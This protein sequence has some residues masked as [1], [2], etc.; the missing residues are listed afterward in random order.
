MKRWTIVVLNLFCF[1]AMFLFAGD[2]KA[3]RRLPGQVNGKSILL[4]NGWSLSPAGRHIPVGDFPLALALHQN[5]RHLL[6]ANNGYGKQSIDVI[7]VELGK[8]VSSEPV[9][10]AWLGLTFNP[11]GTKA[12]AGGGMSNS[13]L[14]FAFNEGKLSPLPPLPVGR[15]LADIFPGGLCISGGRLF[16]A[17]NLSGDVA[18]LDLASGKVAASVKVGDYPYTCAASADGRMVYVSLWGGSQV[19]GIETDSLKV[20]ARIQTED[21]PNAMLFSRDGKRLFVANANNNSVSAIDLAAGK[22]LERISVALYPDSPAGSTTNALA[23]SPDGNTLYVANADNNDLAV[24]DIRK[25]GESK[26]LGFI[27]VGWYPTSVATSRDGRMIYVAN[28]KGN[29]S[30]ANPKGPVTTMPRTSAT[31]Y[32]G[33]LLLGS[34]SLV[35]VPDQAMLAKYTSEV[36]ANIP[37]SEKQRLSVNFKGKSS[38]PL[39]V[40]DKSP[41]EHVIYVIKENRTYDQV[42]GDIKEGNGDPSLT[43]FGEQITPNQHALAREFV[44]LDNFYVDAEVS[45]DGHNWSMGAYA[46]DYVE[47]IWPSQYSGRRRLYDFEGGS[48]VVAPSEGYIWDAC[49]KAGI[50]YRSYGEWVAN[51]ARPGDP[52]RA[53]AS[54]LEGHFDPLYR[55][56]DMQYS[57]IDRAKRFL[58]EVARFEK[59]GGMPRFQVVRMGNDHTQGTKAGTL[60]PS[61]YVAQNDAAL[62]MLVEG[63][64][65]STFWPKTA[66]F[67][68]EDDAQNGP[69]HVDAHRSIAFAISPYIRR[70]TVDSTMYSTSSMLRTMELILGL[71]PMSQYDAAAAPLMASF[72]TKPDLKPFN[73]LPPRVSLTEVN[74]ANAPGAARSSQMDFDEADRAPDLEFN[75]ILWKAIKG[76]DSVMPAPVRSAFVRPIKMDRD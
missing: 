13:V 53:K 9:E 4:P 27:P 48:P 20:K 70:G 65:K 66:I 16:V 10:K 57:D 26:V 67:V 11:D 44:L 25:S 46:T 63:V 60:T 58:S 23:M 75:E 45:A 14:S 36:Y 59:E 69:D 76:G 32:I 61:A 51:G 30:A 6:V 19:V 8:V 68:V 15:P 1:A 42:F 50:T 7:D 21:H 34:V 47:K 40:G 33:G 55:G 41:I 29:Q 71:P 56:W 38:I 64:S 5:G 3:Q 39:K 24:V 2:Q 37:Y 31:Q 72:G 52:S 22:A 28:G 73:A 74:P 12:Y 43:L 35:P 17:N 62:G 54:A 49:K 18:V